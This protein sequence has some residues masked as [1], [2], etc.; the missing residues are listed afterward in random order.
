MPRYRTSVYFFIYTTLN[1]EIYS[2]YVPTTLIK[3]TKVL[4]VGKLFFI[5]YLGT[6]FLH[7]TFR[8]T[9]HHCRR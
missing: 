4:L 5:Y 8:D 7:L 3:D 1:K 9:T 6:T 2:V